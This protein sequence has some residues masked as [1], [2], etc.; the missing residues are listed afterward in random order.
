MPSSPFEPPPIPAHLVHFPTRGGLV[1]PFITLQH[2]N[3]KAALGLVDAARMEL[4]LRER[5]CSVCGSVMADRM[6]FFVREI[7]LRRKCS[8]EPALCPPCAAYTQRVCPMITGRMAHYQ[9]SVSSFPNRSCDDPACACVLWAPPDASSSRLGGTAERWFA[10]WTLQYSL[11]RDDADRL[12]AGFAGLHV[13]R[14]RE[15]ERA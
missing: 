13:L 9:T 8:T 2:R 15:V 1:I 5:R 10:L 4:C 7:D 6:V 3:G 12:A 14:I 11:V